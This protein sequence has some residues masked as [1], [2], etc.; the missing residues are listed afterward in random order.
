MARSARGL[1]HAGSGWPGVREGPRLQEAGPPADSPVGVLPAP[2]LAPALGHG[3]A[4]ASL[5]SQ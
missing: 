1:A 5:R 2:V 3:R 4:I